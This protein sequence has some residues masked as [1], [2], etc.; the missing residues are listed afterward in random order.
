MRL[1]EKTI[2]LTHARMGYISLQEAVFLRLSD[3]MKSCGYEVV[4]GGDVDIANITID[5]RTVK[6]KSLFFCIRGLRNDG[7]TFINAAGERGAAAIIVDSPADA[8]PENITALRVRDSRE[9]LSYAAAE[10][11]GRPA[12]GLSISGVTGTNGKTSVTYFLEA[13]FNA[14][15][16]KNGLIGT[17]E[18]RACGEAIDV[19]FATSTTPDA[20]ELQL[21]LKRMRDKNVSH[22]AMEVTSHALSLRK[23]DGI[24][25]KTGIFTN[26]TQDH[27]DFHG[28]MRN[29][30][31][32]KARL[33]KNSDFSI[34]NADDP[35]GAF[36]IKS[37]AGE[38]LTYGI[39]EQCELRARNVSL[40]AAGVEFDAIIG[41]ASEKFYC[42]IPGKF[43]VYN[44]LAAIGAAAALNAP[45]AAIKTGLKEMKGV[46]GRIERV[47]NHAGINII[48]DY[49]HTPDGVENILTAVREFTPGRLISV[50][51]CGGDRD[52][53]KRP[54][55][56]GIAGKLSDY[57]FITSD[58]PRSENPKSIL[59]EIETGILPTDCAY[60]KIADRR[61]AIFTAVTAAR[62]GD[63]VVIA[64]K[65]HENYQIFADKTI[66]FDD[67]EIAA[68]ALKNR[69]RGI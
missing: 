10:F 30:M 31:E 58:N 3:I 37:A 5:S 14:W 23:T 54:L 32:V 33:F 42:P 39:N 47:P 57:C 17:V 24:R 66:H 62:P 22:V 45:L 16:H 53:K 4:Q 59:D 44:A 28:N 69:V 25:F 36:M 18:T 40:N 34:I 12:D 43:T 68:E 55:M 11:F 61:E 56:G 67:R 6:D 41:G 19:P 60:E 49:A 29:Y 21:I 2:G 1:I 9:A 46:P 7:H 51:G 50:F 65:G 48:V 35:S 52:R 26:L 64:G 38:T 13:I 27:L 8:Y 15:G 20:I 63:S